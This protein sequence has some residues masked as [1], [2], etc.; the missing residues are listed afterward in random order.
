LQQTPPHLAA[1]QEA[2][3]QRAEGEI[4]EIAHS[5]VGSATQV[6]AMRVAMLSAELQAG[7]HDLERAAVLVAR[8]V[9]ESRRVRAALQAMLQNG[10][11][12]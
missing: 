5:L 8:L 6:G 4:E 1:L 10:N 3:A 2:V 9:N 11:F 7:A 12:V